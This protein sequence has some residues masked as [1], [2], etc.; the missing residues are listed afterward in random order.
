MATEESLSKQR[1]SYIDIRSKNP[2]SAKE[3]IQ[4]VNLHFQT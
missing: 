3:G 2:S 1:I 4:W